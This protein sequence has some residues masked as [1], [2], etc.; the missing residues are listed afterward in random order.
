M[1]TTPK[2]PFVHKPLL[3]VLLCAGTMIYLSGMVP[4]NS[5]PFSQWDLHNYRS[6]AQASPH[7]DRSVCPPYVYRLLGPYIVGLFPGSDATGFYLAAILCSLLLVVVYSGYCVPLAFLQGPRGLATM[8]LTMNRYFFG[9]PYG[10]VSRLTT[11]SPK[12][13]WRRFFYACLN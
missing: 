12:C 5:L 1:D 9:L 7:I 13:C 11:S 3:V 2:N 8:L 4:Y 6:M 10:T